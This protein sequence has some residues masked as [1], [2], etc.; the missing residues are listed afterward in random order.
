VAASVRAE[1]A[2]RGWSQ[3]HL[4]ALLGT[5][6]TVVSQIEADRRKLG[7]DDLIALCA[8]LQ[9]PLQRLLAGAGEHQMQVLGL[10]VAAHPR[11]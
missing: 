1:R 6:Q 7:V 10:S 4:A 8:A 2:R 5:K 9:V 11:P 3:A